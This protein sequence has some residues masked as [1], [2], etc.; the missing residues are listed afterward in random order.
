MWR[1]ETKKKNI[2]ERKGIDRA[3]ERVEDEKGK[4]NMVSKKSKQTEERKKKKIIEKKMF[5]MKQTQTEKKTKEK[6][7]EEKEREEGN[8]GED[9]T[10]CKINIVR[11]DL[12][13]LVFFIALSPNKPG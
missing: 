6:R 5:K 8:S 9:N 3:R 1:K 4:W 13:T 11:I 7:T 10:R 2:E 12:A